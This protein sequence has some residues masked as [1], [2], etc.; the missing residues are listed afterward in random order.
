MKVAPLT[1][2]FGLVAVGT[3]SQ[4]KSVKLTNQ[5]TTAVSITAIATSGNYAQSNNCPASLAGGQSC[6]IRVVFQPTAGTVIPG[7]LSISTD[8]TGPAPVS[9]VGTGTS[10][11]SSNVLLSAASLNFGS[12]TVGLFTNTQTVTLTNTSSTSS[13]N[14]QSVTASGFGVYDLQFARPPCSGMLAPGAQCVIVA[15]FN[16]LANLMPASYPGAITIV[17][18]DVTSPQVIGLSGNGSNEL[19]F[20]PTALHFSPQKVGTT[21]PP[22]IVTVTSTLQQS[23]G[24]FLNTFSTGDYSFVGFGTHA[25]VNGEIVPASCTI[26]V[27]FTPSR[28]GVVNGAITFDNYPLCGFDSC[29]KPAVLSL[30]GTGQ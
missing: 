21:S 19:T 14:I 8:A 12:E 23:E 13:L 24:L 26:A 18:N 4:P 3:S 16:P 28:T 30:T 11:P 1:L 25:C 27:S 17:D 20:G 15:F 10:G 29:P 6:N 5:Q 9:L 22:Q 2:N 7:A